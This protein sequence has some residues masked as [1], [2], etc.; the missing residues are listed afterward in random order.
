MYTVLEYNDAGR[1]AAASTG[2]CS[3]RPQ[4][5]GHVSLLNSDDVSD[6]ST[7]FCSFK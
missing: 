7:V 1:A 5:L 3:T 4:H 2:F 6:A